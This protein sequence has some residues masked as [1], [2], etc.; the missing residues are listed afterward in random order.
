MN[1]E[2]NLLVDIAGEAVP[3][4]DVGGEVAT[5]RARLLQAELKAEAIR[6][7]MVD[8][9]GVKLIDVGGVKVDEAGSLVDGAGLMAG[10]RASKPWLFGRSSSSAAVAPRAEPPRARKAMEMTVDEW[11][12]ARAELLRRR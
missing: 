2:N 10:L 12:A 3:V 7:G 5:L 11:K 9:D 8:L 4:A 6:A 1:D